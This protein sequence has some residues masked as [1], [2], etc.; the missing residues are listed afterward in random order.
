MPSQLCALHK[1]VSDFLEHMAQQA[2][3]HSVPETSGQQS[4]A[5]ML[6]KESTSHS[7]YLNIQS[8]VRRLP[9][10]AAYK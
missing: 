10:P 3:A 8:G 4:K 9:P 1:Q 7:R 6:T 2:A 5:F